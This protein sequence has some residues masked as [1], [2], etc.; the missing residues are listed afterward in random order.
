MK[1]YSPSFPSQPPFA[2]AANYRPTAP[3]YP[4][5]PQYYGSSNGFQQVAP[6]SFQSGPSFNFGVAPPMG[7]QFP[8]QMMPSYYSAQP[9]QPYGAAPSMALNPPPMQKPF[10][11]GNPSPFGS[12]P[13]APGQSL[14]QPSFPSQQFNPMQGYAVGSGSG[15][16]QNSGS[17]FNINPPRQQQSSPSY[18]ANNEDGPE[19]PT[20]PTY[21]V[22]PQQ[23][24]QQLTS[25]SSTSSTDYSIDSNVQP[26][27]SIPVR[28]QASTDF[29]PIYPASSNSGPAPSQPY[30]NNFY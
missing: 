19:M 1:Q 7:P 2:P 14:P 10:Y 4:S 13:P 15:L 9:M 23:S 30:E 22:S 17:S 12:Y 20:S 26:T 3:A 16:L 8:Q 5:P 6:P 21:G 28:P 24:Q 29:L 18:G 11:G 27:P 25:Q